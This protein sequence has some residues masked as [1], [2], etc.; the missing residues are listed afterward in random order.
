MREQTNP[1]LKDHLPLPEWMGLVKKEIIDKANVNIGDMSRLLT[2]P[3]RVENEAEESIVRGIKESIVADM[4]GNIGDSD[5]ERLKKFDELALNARNL[6]RTQ[7]SFL[8]QE[9]YSIGEVDKFAE[10]YIFGKNPP[11]NDVLEIFLESFPNQEARDQL[12]AFIFDALQ[13]KIT[14]L[15]AAFIGGKE[16][17]PRFVASW[18][19]YFVKD[20]AEKWFPADDKGLSIFSVKE[21]EAI[22]EILQRLRPVFN[23]YEEYGNV[24]AEDAVD[25]AL[26][27]DDKDVRDL[28]QAG[29]QLIVSRNKEGQG[30]KLSDLTN[31]HLQP[32]ERH[33]DK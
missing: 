24:W 13:K 33:W 3:V 16:V 28:A 14:W 30:T 32:P 2:T 15:G 29:K 19:S 20:L 31:L 25:E 8:V 27:S 1:F 12:S 9:F 22:K 11:A 5:S 10:L 26:K 18:N 4:R 17:L 23:F 6:N 7:D 21:I